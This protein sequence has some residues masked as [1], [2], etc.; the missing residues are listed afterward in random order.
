MGDKKSV[1]HMDAAEA[2][3]NRAK[4]YIHNNSLDKEAVFWLD[5]GITKL[6]VVYNQNKNNPEVRE[7]YTDLVSLYRSILK[8]NKLKNISIKKRISL[9][10]HYISP[11]W[12]RRLISIIRSARS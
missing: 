9:R 11:H 8:D 12:T 5:Y 10:L 3:F 6:L 4:L 1:K 7:R 2:F